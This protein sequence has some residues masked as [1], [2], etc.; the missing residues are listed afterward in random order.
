[1]PEQ[2]ELPQQ[3]GRQEK[4]I[5]NSRKEETTMICKRLTLNERPIFPKRAIITAGMPYGNKNLHFGHV[6]GMFIHADIFARFLRDRIGKENVIFL[7]GT[8]CYGSPIMESYRKLCNEGYEGTLEDWVNNV[9][10][11]DA[12]GD[13]EYRKQLIIDCFYACKVMA[14]LIHPIAPEG[15]EMFRE[16]LN[17]GEE[18]WNWNYI[19]KPISAYVQDIE[20]HELKYLEPRVDFFKKHES[21]L[22]EM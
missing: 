16:Y 4:I 9:K 14:I 10:V 2:S 7:S 19:L 20:N 17:V 3:H 22:I 1:M 13:M 12:T 5:M 21:Q 8:D 18:L 15:C 11:A 6:G